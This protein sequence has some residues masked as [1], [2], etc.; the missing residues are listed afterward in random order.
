MKIPPN[1]LEYMQ[2][3]FNA[4]VRIIETFEEARVKELDVGEYIVLDSEKLETV[5]P[6]FN[7]ILVDAELLWSG[8]AASI[9]KHEGIGAC[10]LWDLAHVLDHSCL[11]EWEKN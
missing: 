1:E 9:N 7:L 10:V 3:C 8:F 6:E 11:K 2:R 5:L 4:A